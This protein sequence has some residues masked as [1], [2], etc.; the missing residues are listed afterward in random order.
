MGGSRQQRWLPRRS[1]SL[2]F[3]VRVSKLLAIG[4]AGTPGLCAMGR[5]YPQSLA[6][7]SVR[8]ARAVP[9][10]LPYLRLGGAVGAGYVLA[11]GRSLARARLEAPAAGAIPVNSLAVNAPADGPGCPS[12]N[13]GTRLLQL[14]CKADLPAS[15]VAGLLAHFGTLRAWACFARWP[16]SA[17]ARTI[18]AES[19]DSQLQ[20]AH[21]QSCI[22]YCRGSCWDQFLPTCGWCRL[23]SRWP[24][25]RSLRF[26]AGCSGRLRCC[27]RLRGL[28]RHW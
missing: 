25:W 23:Q 19:P 28:G 13:T 14:Q 6:L 16:Q 20:R 5:I 22:F 21:S 11:S 24:C 17:F 2:P 9:L 7:A 4:R 10:C 18:F 12:G 3:P 26:E 1:L 8:A 27:S 15:G